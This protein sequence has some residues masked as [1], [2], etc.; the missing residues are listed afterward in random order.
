MPAEPAQ[1]RVAAA[2]PAFNPASTNLRLVTSGTSECQTAGEKHMPALREESSRVW[3]KLKAMIR[4]TSKRLQ[5]VGPRTWRRLA[6]A[7]ARSRS[8]PRCSDAE[9]GRR[10][11]DARRFRKNRPASGRAGGAALRH[12]TSGRTGMRAMTAPTFGSA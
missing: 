1:P 8:A 7:V 11:D 9:E 10:V 3:E 12:V 6:G 2:N 4:A 5:G